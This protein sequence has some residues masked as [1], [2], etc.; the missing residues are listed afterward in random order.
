MR[1]TNTF[2]V[3]VSGIT[4]HGFWLFLDNEELFVSFLDFPWFYQAPVK[5][6]FC[7]ER[8][9]AHHLY[10]SELDIDLH[11]DSIKNPKNYPLISKC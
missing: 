5:K 7:V 2:Q 6:L 11:I 3:E 1:G 8:P 10:W 4:K 9:I